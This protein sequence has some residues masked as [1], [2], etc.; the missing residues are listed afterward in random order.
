MTVNELK[1]VMV[2]AYAY[3]GFP[4]GSARIANPVGVLDGARPP[5]SK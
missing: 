1:E 3:C 2:H 4:A 5:V